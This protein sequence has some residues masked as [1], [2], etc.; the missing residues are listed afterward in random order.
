M[1]FGMGF[2]GAV[3]IIGG[4]LWGDFCCDGRELQN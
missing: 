2:L 3:I 4:M 1:I